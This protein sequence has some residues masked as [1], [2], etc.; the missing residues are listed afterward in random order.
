MKIRSIVLG[1]ATAL[2]MLSLAHAGDAVV[3]EDPLQMQN[4]NVCDAYGT[5]FSKIAGTNTCVKVSGQ[6]RYEKRFGNDRNGS[7]GQ[8]SMDLETR[9]D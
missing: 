6:V 7:H 2:S 1:C 4:V 8:F 9:S 3:P 5:G